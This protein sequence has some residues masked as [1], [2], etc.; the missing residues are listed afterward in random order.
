M[1]GEIVCTHLNGGRIR[2][3]EARFATFKWDDCKG[4][5]PTNCG[6][7]CEVDFYIE[8]RGEQE[9]AISVRRTK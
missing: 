2:Y 7:G 3:G 9:H 5:G 4:L 8:V 6:H 1:R